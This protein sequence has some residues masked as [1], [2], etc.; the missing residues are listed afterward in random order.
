MRFPLVLALAL[1][2]AAVGPPAA[3]AKT[4]S[5]RVGR[6]FPG[7][8]N[9]NPTISKLKAINLP[10]LMDGYAPRCLVAESMAQWAIDDFRQGHQPRKRVWLRGARWNGGH[11]RCKY[12]TVGEQR[13]ASCRQSGHPH[14][15]IT[16][17]LT[18]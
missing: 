13:N 3:S 10:R 12:T 16:Y 5:C 15:R 14:R 11:W 18:P 7:T 4:V 8:P 6:Y 9:V 2:V 17:V 1:A